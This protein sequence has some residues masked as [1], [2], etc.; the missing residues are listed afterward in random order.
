MMG[1][2]AALGQALAVLSSPLLTR[3]Y[4]AE[5][6]GIFGAFSA[7]VTSIGPAAT[8]KFEQ[9]IVLEAD[10]EGAADVVRLCG[11]C[12]LGFGLLAALGF[13]AAILLGQ[14]SWS[15]RNGAVL[16][17]FGPLAVFILGMLN[18]LTFWHTRHRGFHA[19]GIYQASRT[20]L[21]VALQ[22]ALSLF[23]RTGG[24]LI[25]GQVVG[26]GI[27]IGLLAAADQ[28]RLWRILSRGYSWQ[29][30]RALV[31]R[32]RNFALYG[33]PQVALRL[34]SANVPA[35]LLPIL[36]GPTESGLFWLAYRMLVLPN[37]VLMEGLR[38]VFMRRAMDVQTAGGDLRRAT[39]QVL[40]FILLACLPVV[41]LL[42]AVGP[43][44][45]ALVFGP[46][47]RGAGVY[48]RIISIAWLLEN[49][50]YPSSVIVSVL[51]L[52]RAF[53]VLEI[54]S[55][56]ARA[57]AILLA[58]LWGGA[59]LAV[60]CYTAAAS[61]TALAV[62]VYIQNAIPRWQPPAERAR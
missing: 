54:I 28:P 29:R 37:Q 4:E 58:A 40:G 20:G 9:A 5:A 15:A 36:Y 39:R 18:A 52:Q 45:F 3:L 13:S 49:L 53:L 35:I 14:D 10:D 11:L 23:G 51:E 60:I 16:L 56:V 50:T 31:I 62:V 8:L 61:V 41:L 6:F 55:L 21:A 19:L 22:F 27:A 17:G 24:F 59:E 12:S 38:N 44:M 34:L 43:E 47:W 46:G 25:G 2:G 57:A 26:Q 48:A 32:Y 30:L 1:S 7:V 42:F 33:G